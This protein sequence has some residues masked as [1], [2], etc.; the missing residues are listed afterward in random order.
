MGGPHPWQSVAQKLDAVGWRDRCIDTVRSAPSHPL[1]PLSYPPTHLP[2]RPARLQTTTWF[3]GTCAPRASPGARWRRPATSATSRS[4]RT[5]VGG[6]VNAGGWVG[7][8][9]VAVHLGGCM[10]RQALGAQRGWPAEGRSS[11]DAMLHARGG[12]DGQI[13]CAHAACTH[14]MC[15]PCLPAWPAWPAWPAVVGD[16]SALTPGGVR[17]GSPAMTSRGLKEQGKPRGGG[18]VVGWVHWVAGWVG[19]LDGW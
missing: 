19:A 11:L 4:T 13:A 6:G 1:L 9:A 16:V 12:K 3:C 17:I 5:R 7:G 14:L 15:R 8:R 10:G 2:T 18:V